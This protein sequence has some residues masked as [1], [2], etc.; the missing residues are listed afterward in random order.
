MKI[1]PKAA[2][3]ISVIGIIILCVLSYSLFASLSA[4][5]V[6]FLAVL[7]I[8]VVIYVKTYAKN[9][10]VENDLIIDYTTEKNEKGV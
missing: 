4:A 9:I 7:V 3:A 8:A 5:V 10:E 1:S 6:G 2:R